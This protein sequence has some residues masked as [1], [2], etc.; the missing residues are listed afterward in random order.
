[1]E[2]SSSPTPDEGAACEDGAAT[3]VV[4]GAV[5]HITMAVLLLVVP[6]QPL[7]GLGLLPLARSCEDEKHPIAQDYVGN[8]HRSD[9]SRLG[10][11]RGAERQSDGKQLAEEVCEE[12]VPGARR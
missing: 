5:I 9:Q 8:H 10:L 6:L 4:T 12:V 7:Q 11:P 3:L 1:M 2:D